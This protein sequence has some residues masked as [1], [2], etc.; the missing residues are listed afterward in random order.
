[1]NCKYRSVAK[2]YLAKVNLEKKKKS[3]KLAY[4]YELRLRAVT[5]HMEEGYA[6]AM[7]KC[8]V[9]SLEWERIR[10]SPS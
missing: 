7:L 6:I 5:F 2:Y 10:L 1:M 9:K 4:S 3:P 8:L